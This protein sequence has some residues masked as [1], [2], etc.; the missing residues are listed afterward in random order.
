MH[1]DYAAAGEI[2]GSLIAAEMRLVIGAV[3]IVDIAGVTDGLYRAADRPGVERRLFN[4]GIQ[5]QPDP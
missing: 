2:D 1:A 5:D 4:H 3:A